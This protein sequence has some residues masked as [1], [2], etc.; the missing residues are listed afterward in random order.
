MD[1]LAALLRI[2]AQRS[3]ANWRLL[4]TVIFGMVLASALMSSVVLYSDAVRDLGLSFTLRQEEPLALDLKVVSNSQPGEPAVYAERRNTTISLLRRYAGGLTEGTGF[5]G[6]SST[7]FLTEPGEEVRREDELR[8]RAHFLFFS[9]IASHVTLVEGGPAAPA[10]PTTDSSR[11][12][13]IE[14][15]MGAAAARA[16]GARTGETF[17]LH[18]FWRDDVEPVQATIAGLIEPNDASGEYWFGNAHRLVV[19]NTRWPTYPLVIDESTF[20][21]AIAPYLPSIDGTFET[22]AFIDRERVNSRNAETVERN[23]RALE[24]AVRAQLELA[25]VDSRLADVIAEYQQKLFFTRLPLFALML[26]IV[27]IALYYLVLVATMLV[28]R[29]AGEIALLKSRGAGLGQIMTVYLTEGLALTAF[30]VALGPLL[31]AGVIRL[32]G[33]SPPFASLSQGELLRVTLTAEAFGMALLGALLALGALLWP[34]WRAAGATMAHYK[35]SLARP[36]RQPLFL[37]YYLDLA[38]VGVGAFLFYQLRQRGS[39]VTENLFGDLSADP[40]L[41]VSPALFILMIALVFLRLFPVALRAASWALRGLHG[42]TILLSLWRMVRNPLHYSRLILLLLLATSVGMFAAGFR[43]TLDRSFEDR[44]RYEAGAAGRII[45]IRE[46]DRLSTAQ[47]EEA[48][49]AIDGLDGAS[50][51]A[52]LDATYTPATGR[53]VPAEILG[54]GDGFAAAAFW[55]EDFGGDLDELLT[56]LQPDGEEAPPSG[57]TAPAGTRTLGLWTRISLP[58]R[59]ARPGVRIRDERGLLYE[60]ISV[61]EPVAEED[62]WLLYVFDLRQPSSPRGSPP[63]LDRPLEIESVFLS[64]RRFAAAPGRVTALFDDLTA[65]PE[66]GGRDDGSVIEPF[67]TLDRYDSITGASGATQTSI[68]RAEVT[69]ERGRYAAQVTFTYDTFAASAVGLRLRRSA[70]PLRVLASESF[71]EAA[72]VG[73]GDLI[74]LRINRQV[75]TAQVAGAFEFF[76][77]FFPNERNHLLIA[78][79]TALQDAGAGTPR[80]A[81]GITANEVWL[82][83]VEGV[84]LTREWLEEQGIRARETFDAAGLFALESSDPLV[85]ASWEG[86]LFLSF[87]AVL[88]LTALG[89]IVFSYLAAQTRSLEFA[90]LRTMASRAARSWA[91]SP[92]SSS[93]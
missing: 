40:L 27:G 83:D 15:W 37:R 20:V 12:P 10:L 91:S 17:D 58:D 14:V 86:I 23:L 18:P 51:A 72:G 81:G 36:V 80:V 3:R 52:R 70:A 85:A 43:A 26:L 82:S 34:A 53:S 59:A 50:A 8:P 22:Y 29:Q 7:F 24:R 4:A 88:L 55:R 1:S 54:T 84:A 90:I 92:S 73:T 47:L 42:P 35:Q 19:D 89:F 77:G 66:G 33:P 57:A 21:E 9:G 31:A 39:L 71:L 6:R 16:L 68:T 13:V 11:R 45:D 2:V 78:D 79:L 30:A 48:I 74:P 49:E 25:A 56:R 32:L 67:E 46:P 87:G 65:W 44:A 63:T 69:N 38:L 28:E 64:V 41:L 93:S 75:L 62:G 61:Q 76:P 60:Y 5:Y